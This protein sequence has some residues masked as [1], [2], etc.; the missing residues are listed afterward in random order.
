MFDF[1]ENYKTARRAAAEG[2]VLLKND[3]NALPF[4]STDK[5]G[6]IG[7]DS[8]DLIRGG[9]GS[10]SVISLYTKT[11]P[12]GLCEKDAEGK[13]SLYK[14]STELAQDKLIYTVDELNELAKHINKAIVVI[15]RYATEG[16][17][18]NI[19]NE[20]ETKAEVGGEVYG[21]LEDIASGFDKHGYYYS[22]KYERLL[23][24]NFEK[25][26]ISE[27]IVVLNIASTVD[28]TFLN[29]YKKV[30]AILCAYLPGMEGGR[31][32]VDVL[33]GDVNPSG[34]LTDTFA[35]SYDDYPSSKYYNKSRDFSEY[36]EGIFVGYRYF[37]TF[38]RDRV[39]YPFGFGLSYTTFALSNISS[40]VYDRCVSVKVTVTNTGDVAGKEVVQVYYHAPEG[41][42]KKPYVE[43]AAYKKTRLLQ[44]CESQE[45]ILTF[46]LGDMASF[47]DEGAFKGSYILEKGDYTFFVG[48]SIR[49]ITECGQYSLSETTVTEKLSI[50]LENFDEEQTVAEFEYADAGINKGITLYDIAEG[51]NTVEEFVR[52]FTA[53]EL[54]NLSQAQKPDFAKGT[55]GMG[56]LRKY[57]IPNPQTADGPAGL[58]KSVPTTCIPCATLLAASYDPEL[59]F[60]VGKA[61]GYEGVS[62]GVDILLAPGLNIHRD[63]LC[64]RGFEYYSE[65]P[66]ISGKTAAAMV[67]GIQSQ[68]LCAT[69]KHFFA[70]NC[71]LNRMNN[72]S[73]L[74][75]RTA[76]EIYLEG[77]EI[78]VKEANPVFVMSSYNL[79]N[80]KRCST[81]KNLLTHILRDEWGFEGAVMTDWRNKSHLW[82]EIK[83]GNNLKMP[84]GYPDEI[85]LAIEKYNEGVLTRAELESSVIP[86]LGCIMMTKRFKDKNFGITHRISA[87][88]ETH[89]DVLKTV[90]ISSTRSAIGERDGHQ[91]LC[92]LVK[93]QR[94]YPAYVFYS[95]DAESAGEYELSLDIKT[96]YPETVIWLDIDGEHVAHI[97]CN[98]A[99]DA[100]KWYTV[101][102]RIEL[103]RGKHLI[104]LMPVT[105]PAVD[106]EDNDY[107]YKEGYWDL[108]KFAIDGLV[109]R[110]K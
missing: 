102:A 29:N 6:L 54:I 75:E 14:P 41:Q 70:N 12:D 40:V 35:L 84:F 98:I 1:S 45:L 61:L 80:G 89:I 103:C 63:P 39:L 91:H 22:H 42:L 95:I 101:S 72:D 2:M 65:D 60:E 58:R 48:N 73:R 105:A 104:K 7:S 28:L 67:K 9:G 16:A 3:G 77:F 110:K 20:N 109:I 97:P 49:N 55:A 15:K 64:G 11:L 66:Y 27:V 19:S 13:L 78:A 92:S 21:S 38:A 83:A 87:N 74:S 8:L 26:D 17:D 85:A 50:Q 52:Q 23:F 90:G 47:D 76:R 107:P 59:V 79:V 53:E 10:A 5:V 82:E 43:L 106:P 62:T 51:K 31:A 81:C 86:T 34:K 4:K 96:D 36:K 71:E 32:I 108:G 33:C 37:E 46:N 18:R 93:D 24:E 88:G 68:G 44:P 94:A 56:D 57:L 100:E 99:I 69:I 25:S 30:K